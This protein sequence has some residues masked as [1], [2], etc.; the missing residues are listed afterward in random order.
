[1]RNNSRTG[2]YVYDPFLGSGTSMI[3]AETLDRRCLGIEINPTYVQV[4]VE[5]WQKMTGKVATLDGKTTEEVRETRHSREP[6]SRGNASTA[7]KKSKVRR[8]G[9]A[10]QPSKGRV[11]IRQPSAVAGNSR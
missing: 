1:M 8:A 3:A 7:K 11:A 6:V 9:D 5:R 10:R 4:A 2:E